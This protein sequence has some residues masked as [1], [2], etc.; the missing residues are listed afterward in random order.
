MFTVAVWAFV[1]FVVVPA[2][3]GSIA[4]Y[5]A[6]RVRRAW[7]KVLLF[8]SLILIEFVAL[9]IYTSNVDWW[10]VLLAPIIGNVGLRI[11]FDRPPAK[12]ANQR[13]H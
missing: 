5:F 6:L 2:L 9:G 4:L 10:M 1:L 12:Q 3:L 8:L 7:L 13:A 11:L